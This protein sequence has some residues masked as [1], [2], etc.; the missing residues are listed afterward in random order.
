MLHAL[1]F[2]VSIGVLLP[3]A[4]GHFG[5]AFSALFAAESICNICLNC[6]ALLATYVSLEQFGDKLTL[7]F[8]VW[9]FSSWVPRTLGPADLLWC[10]LWVMDVEC[11]LDVRSLASALP[12]R[13]CLRLFL[14]SEALGRIRSDPSAA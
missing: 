9:V 3:F 4:L 14:L 6:G 8:V 1:S 12:L 13:R 5:L 10:L 7:L 2:N 11:W